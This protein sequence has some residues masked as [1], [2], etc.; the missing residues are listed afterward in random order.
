MY[1]WWSD[2]RQ[3]TGGTTISKVMPVISLHL[4]A[5]GGGTRNA[6]VMFFDTWYAWP[7]ITTDHAQAR[8]R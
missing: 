2:S 5:Y 8:L 4:P 6:Y 7:N 3:Q 1:R